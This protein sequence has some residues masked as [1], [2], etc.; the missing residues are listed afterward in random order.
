[1]ALCYSVHSW[2]ITRQS[3]I[4][5]LGGRTCSCY[6]TCQPYVPGWGW[7]LLHVVVSVRQRVQ[8]KV[9]NE[10][11]GQTKGDDNL[12]TA[13]IS[14]WVPI[15]VSLGCSRVRSTKG[16]VP[17]TTTQD[18]LLNHHP[19]RARGVEARRHDD[20]DVTQRA[21]DL[22]VKVGCV[23]SWYV[24]TLSDTLGIKKKRKK[25]LAIYRT[26]M[27]AVT[28][29]HHAWVFCTGCIAEEPRR[30]MH[31]CERNES[32]GPVVL[33]LQGPVVRVQYDRIGQSAT[34]LGLGLFPVEP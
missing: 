34:E 27:L 24:N 6:R 25:I 5:L 10:I 33:M 1:M 29:M 30:D 31:A 22:Y 8:H 4:G 23:C 26:E 18:A 7:R 11:N 3:R 15:S 12:C 13:A 9:A 17:Q 28:C 20:D 14:S 19:Q 32:R 21:S 2:L 16:S